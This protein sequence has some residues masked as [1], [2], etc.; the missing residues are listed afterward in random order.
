[1]LSWYTLKKKQQTKN[2]QPSGVLISAYHTLKSASMQLQILTSR[3]SVICGFFFNFDMS[4]YLF[5]YPRPQFVM[6]FALLWRYYS[7]SVVFFTFPKPLWKLLHFWIGIPIS[8][9]QLSLMWSS[10]EREWQKESGSVYGSQGFSPVA[11]LRSP[12]CLRQG[13]M[14]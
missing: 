7:F 10:G 9:C 6:Y 14:W 12:P 11:A 3:K 4:R 2:K 8:F 1:M 5:L 13:R